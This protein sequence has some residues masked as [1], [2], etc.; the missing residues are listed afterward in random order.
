MYTVTSYIVI[1]NNRYKNIKLWF[2]INVNSFFSSVILII[3][4]DKPMNVCDQRFHMFEI[5]R[6]KPELQVICKT[7]TQVANEGNLSN[8][9]D[10]I[11]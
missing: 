11:V 9:K 6:Q 3:I 8:S 1:L 4:E 5:S 10:L 2:Y 7:L